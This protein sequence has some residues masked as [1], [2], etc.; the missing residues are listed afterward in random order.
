MAESYVRSLTANKL[1]LFSECSDTFGTLSENQRFADG[2]VRTVTTS[3]LKLLSQFSEVW[4]AI[5]FAGIW[6]LEILIIM[7]CCLVR[8]AN[9]GKLLV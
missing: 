6:G 7:P 9:E 2:Y 4:P 5:Q 3:K 8:K 1:K